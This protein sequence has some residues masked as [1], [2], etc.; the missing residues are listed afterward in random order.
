MIRCTNRQAAGSVLMEFV[1]VVPI[2]LLL[3]GGVFWIGELFQAQFMRQNSMRSTA[4]S[5]GLREN[6]PSSVLGLLTRRD[7]NNWIP[8]TAFG[9][10]VKQG[11]YLA[12]TSQSWLQVAG[13]SF[14]LD[15]RPPAWTKGWFESGQALMS[16]EIQSG[17]MAERLEGGAVYEHIVVMRTKGGDAVNSIRRKWTAHGSPHLGDKGTSPAVNAEWRKVV[18]PFLG[19]NEPYPY[20]NGHPSLG[21][22]TDGFLYSVPQNTDYMRF[23]ILYTWGN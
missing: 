8:E 20:D 6:R 2:Y 11:R 12:N 13:G 14:S 16:M 18:T 9:N 23:P 15:Y 7:V 5:Y 4:W 10:A 1:L 21:S 19:G 22:G 17:A 3:F